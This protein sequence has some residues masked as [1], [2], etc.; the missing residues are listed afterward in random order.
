M[1]KVNEMYEAP[2]LEVAE[3]EV[4]SGIAGSLGGAY[5]G[6]GEPGQ[7]GDYVEGDG[8]EY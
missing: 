3:I 5:G 2:F 7:G 1:K 6:Y 4:E 8:E